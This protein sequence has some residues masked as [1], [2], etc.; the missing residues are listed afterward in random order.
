ME[1]DRTSFWITAWYFWMSYPSFL[2]AKGLMKSGVGEFQLSAHNINAPIGPLRKLIKA[3]RAQDNYEAVCHAFFFVELLI[4]L[5][6]M[7]SSP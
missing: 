3:E 1:L 7:F 4:L 6:V 5:L 2:F